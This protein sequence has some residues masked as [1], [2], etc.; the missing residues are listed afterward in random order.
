MKPTLYELTDGYGG[1]VVERCDPDDDGRCDKATFY[2]PEA[3]RQ[4]RDFM[5]AEYGA[6]P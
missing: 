1:C 6:E 2:G 3:E 4:A 5:V